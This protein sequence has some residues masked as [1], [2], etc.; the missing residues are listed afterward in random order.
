MV[1]AFL[2]DCHTRWLEAID[3]HHRRKDDDVGN[4]AIMN[5]MTTM[6]IE[7][8]TTSFFD[9]RTSVEWYLAAE[10]HAPHVLR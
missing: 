2:A 7:K 8:Y 9:A 5:H 6:T 10:A 3:R 4:D 1:Q